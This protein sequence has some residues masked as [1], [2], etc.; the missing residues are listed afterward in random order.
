MSSENQQSNDEL[1]YNDGLG[2]LLR[3][4]EKRE[5]SWAK[6]SIVLMVIIF[7][8]FIGLTFI[9]NMSTSM[10]TDSKQSDHNN[11]T[12][13]QSISEKS[14]ADRMSK[15]N[16]E[17]KRLIQDHTKRVPA[18]AEKYTKKAEGLTTIQEPQSPPTKKVMVK[19]IA[20][21]FKELDNAKVL[22]DKLKELNI[23]S[24]IKPVRMNNAIRYHV[25]T[26]AFSSVNQAKKQQEILK[27]AGFDT[28]L[29]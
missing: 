9:F 3:E 10:I 29:L 13:V 14:V 12:T 28:Q 23:D 5:F 7:A 24:F 20:G 25:Q 1:E 16:E 17:N 21:S 6:T 22:R 11:R 2:D 15:I 18:T 8:I 26:G 27:T 19:V 4:K